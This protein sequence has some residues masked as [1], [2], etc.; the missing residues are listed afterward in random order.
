MDTTTIILI[1]ITILCLLCG[2]YFLFNIDLC[3]E[4]TSIKEYPKVSII[5][6]A[7]NEEHNIGKLLLSVNNQKLK[8]HEVIVVN[9]CSTDN[10]RAIAENF[11]AK[12]LESKSLPE[13]WMGKPWACW[14]GAQN[15]EGDVFLFLDA[16]TNVEPDS[17]KK[18]IDSYLFEN[19]LDI[20][21]KGVVLSIAPYHKIDKLYEEFSALFNIIMVGSMNAFTPSGNNQPTGLFGQSLLV[22]RN[23]YFA[24][25]G[26]SS[27][28]NK[29]LE[30]V[31]MAEKFKDKGIK[32]K[33]LGGKGT[34]SFRMYPD[35]LKSLVNGWTKAF[36][37]GAGQTPLSTLLLI[38]FWLSAGFIA[39][40]NLTLEIVYVKSIIVWSL[41]YLTF[42]LQMHW[43]LRRIGTFRF[44]SSL[45]FPV[46]LLFYVIVFFRSLYFQI[47]KKSISWKSREVRN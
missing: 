31:F 17:M 2:F 11:G 33:C 4:Q 34:L 12:V 35:G 22:S 16:D 43:M 41:L 23:N 13:G 6:P 28:K 37:A 3:K 40:I 25:E 20:N 14:Q 19:S 15:A 29:I 5:I 21:R 1:T 7:R 27:V 45:L 46:N 42:A 24:I 38:I 36:A 44:L 18:I 10:T 26:H 39:S 8:V 32:L 30:N 9:D 47:S